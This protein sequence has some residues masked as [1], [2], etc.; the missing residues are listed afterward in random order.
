MIVKLF[1]MVKDEEDIIE[2][3][4][5]YHGSIF[6]YRNLYIVDNMSTDGTFEKIMKYRKIGVQV[7][8]ETDYKE[9]GNYMTRLIKNRRL[10]KYDIAFPIDI[11][12]FIVH[13]DK[14]HNAINP[15]HTRKYVN[16]YLK[17]DF[18]NYEVFKCNYIETILTTSN[19]NG[20]NNALIETH[21]GRYNDYKN[22]AK[23]F[24]N[25]SKW[26]GV[27][28]HGNH[29]NTDN[30]KLSDLCLVHYHCRGLEQ[31][32]K[33]IINNVK[34][35]GY[36]IDYENLKEVIKNNK[37]AHGSHHIVNMIKILENS[38]TLSLTDIDTIAPDDIDLQP[39]INYFARLA[40]H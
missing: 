3:W 17:K 12:E 20:Y 26:N 29:Y 8:R 11:D 35:L 22:L 15:E 21:Y 16:E 36:E 5:N 34:G 6:G 39:L 7:F 32:K 31:M 40:C 28:D 9:K 33:K 19:P 24:F 27:L 4:I 10:G 30:Y 37:N 25:K 2:Y 14:T 13:F 1:T 23:T 38:Y 18:N